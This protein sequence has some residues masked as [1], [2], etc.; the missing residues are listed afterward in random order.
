MYMCM[1]LYFMWYMF[2]FQWNKALE[3][4]QTHNMKEIK[5]LLSKY[6]SHLLEKNKILEVV[7]L[8]RRANH[9]LE[10]AKLL[11]KV[12]VTIFFRSFF[13][14][15]FLSFVLS[16]YLSFFLGIY[17]FFFLLQIADEEAKKRTRPLHVK[18]LY[19][20]AACLVE[21]HRAHLKTSQQNKP[22][23]KRSEVCFVLLILFLLHIECKRLKWV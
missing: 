19:V 16:F 4:T 10:A 1:Y 13:R 21:N 12:V 6:A 7:E 22:K 11:F 3:L 2:F 18:K 8:Y 20:L 23:G 14:S 5:P 17:L 9:F 15:V